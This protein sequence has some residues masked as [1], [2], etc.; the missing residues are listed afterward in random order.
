[1][2]WARKLRPLALDAE[3]SCRTGPG[4]LVL[5]NGGGR[6]GRPA[7]TATG[8]PRQASRARPIPS[9]GDEWEKIFPKSE[10]SPLG[11]V[12]GRRTDGTGKAQVQGVALRFLPQSARFARRLAKTPNRRNADRRTARAVGGSCEGARLSW[13]RSRAGDKALLRLGPSERYSEVRCSVVPCQR[14]GEDYGRGMKTVAHYATERAGREF[15]ARVSVGQGILVGNEAGRARRCVVQ[16]IE[17]SPEEAN[18][19]AWEE[20]SSSRGRPRRR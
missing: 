14:A 8:W 11:N 6:T 5:V 12:G 18:N 7:Q 10:P 2:P 1:M 20:S 19:E 15:L 17:A 3:I 4:V 16:Y 9:R 13:S